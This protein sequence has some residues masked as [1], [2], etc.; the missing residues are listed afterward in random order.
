MDPEQVLIAGMMLAVMVLLGKVII[1][2]AQAYSRKLEGSARGARSA[3]EFAELEARVRELEAR[4]SR[5]AE[6]E[7]RM[8]FN[9]RMLAQQRDPSRLGTGEPR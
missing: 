4:E 7:E 5:V 2:I 3:G 1:P 8:D 6:L 9:E